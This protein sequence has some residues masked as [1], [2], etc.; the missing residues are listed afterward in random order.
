M[1]KIFKVVALKNKNIKTKLPIQFDKP[2]LLYHQY[3]YR[4]PITVKRTA[5]PTES[6][7]TGLKNFFGGIK[8]AVIDLFTSKKTITA[9][10]Q[11]TAKIDNSMLL[12]KQY[13]QDYQKLYEEYLLLFGERADKTLLKTPEN[14]TLS[15]AKICIGNISL[16][17]ENEKLVQKLEKTFT[18]GASFYLPQNSSIKFKPYQIQE[19]VPDENN[20]FKEELKRMAIIFL[21]NSNSLDETLKSFNELSKNYFSETAKSIKEIFD[22]K[23]TNKW[24]ERIPKLGII[25]KVLR[26]NDQL[27]LT[28]CLIN[29]YK[30]VSESYITNG[31]VPIVNKYNQQYHSIQDYIKK[32]P[33]KAFWYRNYTKKVMQ[34]LEDAR[35]MRLETS[36]KMTEQFA[37]GGIGINNIYKNIKKEGVISVT[38]K[39]I[40]CIMPFL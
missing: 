29:D 6:L 19:I 22:L 26:I 8:T 1:T 38:R 7:I 9:T 15:N 34:K 30:G 35:K 14:I 11:Q 28:K 36:A 16:E 17:I 25:P 21:N 10:I 13:K 24:F 37:R 3:K 27:R 40:I 31:V 5:E 32:H 18:K 2:S 23:S 4:E 33:V 20:G 12:L 39:A